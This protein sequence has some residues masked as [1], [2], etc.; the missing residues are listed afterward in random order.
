MS[1]AVPLFAWVAGGVALAT[2]ALHLL[3]WRRPPESLLPTARFAP[4]RPVR[5]VSRA[6]RPADLALLVLRVALVLLVGFALAGLTV[7][8]R[9][10]GTAHVV[11]VD[12]SREAGA[13]SA[14]AN[15]A[16]R[17][18]R[19]GDALV[20]FDSV[21]REVASPS[22]DSL[23]EKSSGAPGSVS[24]AL[25]AATRAA[26]RLE[27]AH[28]SVEIVIVSPFAAGEI[29][30]ATASIRA[31]WRGAVRVVRAGDVPND[32]VAS[33]RATVR[34][35]AGDPVAAALALAGDTPGGADVRVT[36]DAPTAA[37][38]AW[39]V[40]GH[41][42]VVWPSATPSGWP[43]R[44]V[45]DTVFAVT[46][47][48]AHG[49][50]GWS[51]PPATVVAPLARTVAPP[52]GRVV[53]RWSDGEPAATELSLGSGCV[54]A[55]AVPVPSVGDLA[56]TP[57]FGRFVRRMVEP[58]GAVTGG[59]AVGDSVL[60]ATIPAA[61]PPGADLAARKATVM[62]RSSLTPWLLGLALLAALAELVVRRGDADAAAR[63]R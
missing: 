1:V 23:A 55:V 22:V 36:R 49:A 24:A 15:A 7:A 25:V 34:S 30:A 54:R 38:S 21:A 40:A 26:R 50:M 43:A 42:L 51:L 6:V 47:P 16:R 56:L 29:D 8:P 46:A 18:L 53:A 39:A 17:E 60:A 4:E 44:R 3:A 10:E 31:T 52:P 48:G 57:A 5:M 20:T 62:P 9:R 19:A 33:G 61:P 59:S 32:S 13:G 12:R 35:P 58:C 14:V 11:V 63:A 2:V 45:A 27:R 28:D 37:D 41:A